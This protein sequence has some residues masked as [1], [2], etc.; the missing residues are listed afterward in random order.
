MASRPALVA[1]LAAALVLVAPAAG[2][3]SGKIERLHERVAAAKRRE[4]ALTAQIADVTTRI[5]SLERQV[6]DVS[7]RLTLLERDLALHRQRLQ[8]LNELYVFETK[9]LQFLRAQYRAS[10]TELNR[11]LVQ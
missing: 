7:Q 1:A 6:G 10:L 3:N 8:K 2:D 9:R 11:R 4:A 5:R